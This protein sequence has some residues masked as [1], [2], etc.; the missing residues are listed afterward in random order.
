MSLL[1]LPPAFTQRVVNVHPAL[2]PSFGGKGF[3]GHK[4]HEAVLKY[5]CKVSGC[6]VHFVDDQ[7]DHGP[8]IAQQAVPVLPEDTAESLAARVQEAERELYPRAIQ[9]YAA[10]AAEDRGAGGQSP[11]T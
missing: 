6:T 1:K 11:L 2:L 8:I 10:G 5:G 9:L 3:Y 7:Y 4:V